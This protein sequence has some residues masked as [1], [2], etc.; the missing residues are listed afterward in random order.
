VS[1]R[2]AVITFIFIVALIFFPT[3]LVFIF[4]VF[5]FFLIWLLSEENIDR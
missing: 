3:A 5:I 4:I 1:L 2:V